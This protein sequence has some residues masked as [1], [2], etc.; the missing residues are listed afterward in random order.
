MSQKILIIDD[1][2][3]IRWTLE[4]HLV[5][6]GYDVASADSAEKGLQMIAEDRPDLILLD[7]RLPEMTGLDL[8]EML[9]AQERGIMV[10]MLTAYGV[11]E[12]A[13][14][15]M[16]LGAYDYISKPF[17]LEE[18]TVTIKKAFEARS[19]RL[20]DEAASSGM[21]SSVDGNDPR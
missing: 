8:L 11:V 1:E 14:K 16:K 2:Q 15:A 7:N 17:N 18:I 19:L 12:A 4:Q 13:G 9:N 6:E 20:S 3:L 5:K 10:V 21:Q